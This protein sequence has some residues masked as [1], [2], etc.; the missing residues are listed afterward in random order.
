MTAAEHAP[1]CTVH[2]RLLVIAPHPDDETIATGIL[3]QRVHAAGGAVDI[4]LLTDG[5]NN[6]WPQRALERRL[7]IDA[8]ARGRWA[9]RRRSELAQA[10]QHLGVSAEHVHALGWPDL[11]VTRLLLQADSAAV[12][13]VAGL[14]ERLRP[15]L[16]IMPALADRH[17]DH[18]SA[19]VLARLALVG[20]AKPPV[21]WTYGV[22]TT[23]VDTPPVEPDGTQTQRANKQVALAAH[24][25]QMA[26]SGARMRRLAARHEH[27][28]RLP[29]GPIKN[30]VLPWQP[31]AWLGS[32]LRLSVVDSHGARNWRWSQA[33][34]RHDSQGGVHLLPPAG[35][36]GGPR[37]ARLELQLPSPWI[38]DH[39]GWCEL[40]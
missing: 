36:G 22:H 18:A 19:H 23:E 13:T 27:F 11:G 4:L 31:P 2:T 5:D 1:S 12:A 24:A 30:D 6:P 9:R 21:Q 25:S 20:V 28:V 37:F 39:W 38:F 8:D 7:Y 15:N 17:P 29:A 34:V 26:L 35:R 32:R 10:M 33:P 14:F 40:A 16:L 3:I